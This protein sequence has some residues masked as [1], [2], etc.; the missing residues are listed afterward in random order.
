MRFKTGFTLIELMIVV[1]IIG[2]LAA[3]AI[4]SFNRYMRESKQSEAK[5]MLRSV[6]DGALSFYNTEHSYDA[7]GLDV[8]KDLYPGCGNVNGAPVACNNRSTYAQPRVVGKKISHEDPNVVLNVMPWIG[9]NFQISKP[10][11]Y[12]IRY[13]STVGNDSSFTARALASLESNDDSVMH[14]TGTTQGVSNIIPIVDNP[15]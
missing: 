13:S 5:T 10:F 12:E 15:L 8:R 2:I 1:A 14:I 6:A 7:R 4:P 3:T 9:L 11:Y